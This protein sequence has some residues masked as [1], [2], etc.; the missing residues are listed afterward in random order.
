MQIMSRVLKLRAHSD[1]LIHTDSSRSHLIVTL[2]ISSKSP[3]AVALGEMHSHT[4][5]HALILSYLHDT[6][7]WCIPAFSAFSILVFFHSARRLQ[8]AKKDMQRSTH[9]EWWSPRCHR[10]NL[11]AGNSSDELVASP[12]TS[13][14]PSPSHSPCPSPRP[15]I[16]Q[17]SFRTK[18]QLVDLAG[19]ECVGKTASV[20]KDVLWIYRC[21]GNTVL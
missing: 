6:C 21:P 1:T 8:S 9:R 5:S 19:S 16:S 4:H 20:L 14:C 11:A 2:T 15:S 7:N 13:P 10:A 17:T 12:A 3:N 18:L